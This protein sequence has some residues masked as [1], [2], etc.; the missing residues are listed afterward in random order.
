MEYLTQPLLIE[1]Y[2]QAATDSDF[3]PSTE[4]PRPDQPNFIVNPNGEY[5][6]TN[7]WSFHV[8]SEFSENYFMEIFDLRGRRLG[9]GSGTLSA[10]WNDISP[11]TGKFRVVK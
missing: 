5:Q 2:L 1:Q 6:G 11:V 3:I 8:H 7:L 4:D 10:G 9:N